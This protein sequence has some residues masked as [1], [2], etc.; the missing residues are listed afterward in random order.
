MTAISSVEECVD[1]CQD[2]NVENGPVVCFAV[3]WNPESEDCF[4]FDTPDDASMM[5]FTDR[6]IVHFQYNPCECNN[7][8]FLS[9]IPEFPP[10]DSSFFPYIL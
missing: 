10:V 9:I 2:K 1:Y 3:D 5:N 8:R 4:M 7:S 6:F